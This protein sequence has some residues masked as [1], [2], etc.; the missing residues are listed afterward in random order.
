MTKTK[1]LT[2]ALHRQLV[3]L[4]GQAQDWAAGRPPCRGFEPAVGICHNLSLIPDELYD[5]LIENVGSNQ[6]MEGRTPYGRESD[7]PKLLPIMA[8]IAKHLGVEN[9]PLLSALQ[10]AHD[11]YLADDGLP[12]WEHRMRSIARDFSLKYKPAEGG[13][14]S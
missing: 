6:I 3:Q 8:R 5:P 9:E 2:Q 1:A 14:Q 10:T 12:A 13:G 7:G 11:S 4:R